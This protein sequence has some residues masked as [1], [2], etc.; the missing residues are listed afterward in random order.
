VKFVIEDNVV[1]ADFSK[2]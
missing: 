1:F 2:E